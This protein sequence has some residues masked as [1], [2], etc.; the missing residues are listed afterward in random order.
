M[1]AVTENQPCQEFP[2]P[3]ESLS[4]QP[5]FG[6]YATTGRQGGGEESQSSE[7]PATPSPHPRLRAHP[8]AHK[9]PAGAQPPSEAPAPAPPPSPPVNK[10]GG[11]GP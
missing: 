9:N 1:S 2:P 5:F 10:T 11:A 6:K 7:S 8:E 4:Y 3:K